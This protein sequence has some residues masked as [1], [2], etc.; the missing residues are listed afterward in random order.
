[1]SHVDKSRCN[2]RLFVLSSR[3]NTHITTYLEKQN[4]DIVYFNNSGVNYQTIVK[5][6]QE[7]NR[8][9]P[10]VLHTHLYAFAFAFPWVLTHRIK[11]IHTIHSRPI[12]ELSPKSQKLL[13]ILYRLNIVAPV[14][15]SEQICEEARQLYPVKN[16]DMIYNPVDVNRFHVP[17]RIYERKTPVFITA[18][19]LE[20]VKNQELLL[21]AFSDIS[22]KYPGIKLIIA[23]EGSLKDELKSL[24]R[25]LDLS[26]SVQFLGNVEN[27]ELYFKNADIFVLTSTYEGLPLTVLEAMAS[28]LPIISTNVG[29]IKDVVTDNG[30]LV[31]DGNQTE[32]IQAMEK[33]IQDCNL[34]KRL[35]SNSR[36][37][38]AKFDIRNISAQYQNL[39]FKY[40]GR[41][42]F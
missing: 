22:K 7:L 5:L 20:K 37:H 28:G 25:Q 4:T 13:K 35:G 12:Y 30:L 34:R 9:K 29:G 15:I 6:Y 36:L 24:C 14:A 16:I 41:S 8:F 27:V 38:V 31:D 42:S 21:R 2:I 19:R 18:G 10:D 33:L 17:D 40:A 3:V 32:L 11:M 26:D 1:V 23:G 39:Y